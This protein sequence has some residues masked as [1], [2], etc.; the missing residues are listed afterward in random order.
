[1]PHPK[2]NVGAALFALAFLI[3]PNLAQASDN[4]LVDDCGHNINL[5]DVSYGYNLVVDESGAEIRPQGRPFQE[6]YRLAKTSSYVENHNS[7]EYARIF[8]FMGQIRDALMCDIATVSATEWDELTRVLVLNNIK[9]TQ[10]LTGTPKEQYYS[11]DGIYDL[12]SS[13]ENF[14]PMMKYLEEAELELKCLAFKDFNFVNPEGVNH[15]EVHHL[16]EGAGLKLP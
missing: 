7:R 3:T 15:C 9:I 1:M 16:E 11:N 2:N 5:N 14:H 10:S 12:I 8:A 13:G 6:G 4:S